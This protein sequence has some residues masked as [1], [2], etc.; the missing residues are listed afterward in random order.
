MINGNGE[1]EV[2][3][4]F[5]VCEENEDILRQCVLAFKDIDEA[6]T[7]VKAILTDKDMVEWHV[8]GEQF[9][10]AVLLLCLFHKQQRLKT[11]QS[12]YSTVPPKE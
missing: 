5:L 1:S 10:M 8:F 7:N 2:A 6:W 9:P 4:V 11:S 3:A 12:D